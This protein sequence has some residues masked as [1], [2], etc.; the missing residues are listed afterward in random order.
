[1]NDAQ[2]E[3][4]PPGGLLLDHTADGG[5]EVEAPD[6][7]TLFERAAAGAEALVET[8]SSPAAAPSPAVETVPIALEAGDVALLLA[9]WLRELLFLQQVRGK[10]LRRAQFDELT[11]T[12]LSARLELA[13]AGE[14]IREIKGVTYHGLE[15]S[16]DAEGWHARIIFDV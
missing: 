9:D 4:L 12:R 2:P 8:T 13:P 16:R 10:S 7:P 11:T 15:V 14:A 3:R 5:L 1:M 6:L